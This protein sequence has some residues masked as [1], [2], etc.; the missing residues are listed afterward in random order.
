MPLSAE[1]YEALSPEE[2]RAHDA[3]E[4]QREKDEQA[5]LPYRW[6]QGLDY[7]EVNI[8]VP[9]GTRSKQVEIALQR[10]RLRAAVHGN[11]IVE[12]RHNY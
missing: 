2:Q 5:A 8:P 10:T 7:V 1:A 3:A 11:V 4:A 9:E 6:M 12:V